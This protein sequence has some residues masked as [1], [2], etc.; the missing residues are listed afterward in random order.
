MII[1]LYPHS[2]TTVSTDIKLPEN[3]EIKFPLKLYTKGF[4]PAKIWISQ[5]IKTQGEPSEQGE[6]YVN[7]KNIASTRY[8]TDGNF[9]P[10]GS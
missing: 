3:T 2:S 5:Q 4:T 6:A 10:S 7:G 8:D 9:S 1:V